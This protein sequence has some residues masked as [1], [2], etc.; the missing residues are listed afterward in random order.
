M[1]LPFRLPFR[2]RTH[3]PRH[4]FTALVAITLLGACDDPD[5]GISGSAMA[6][7]TLRRYVAGAAAVS[8]KS[9]G[10]FDLSKP[11]APG[12]RPIITSEE[13]GRLA[14]A[15][16]RSWGPSLQA[17]W[18]Q[19]RGEAIDISSL[20]VGPRTVFARTP[21]GE[22]PS[23]QHPAIVRV[24]GPYYLV[25]LY[26][27]SRPVLL[28]AVAAYNEGTK[29]NNRGLIERA[30]HRGMEFVAQALPI[31]TTEVRIV[32]PEEAVESVA[33]ATGAR[34]VTTPEL[35]RPPLP[36]SPASAMWKLTLDR[37]VSVKGAGGVRRTRQ[38][39]VGPER[40]RR[41]M[42]A[43]P[44]NGRT[45]R[46]FGVDVSGQS[47]RPVPI[48]LPIVDGESASYERVDLVREGE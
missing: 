38:I 14:L 43:M 46:G 20:T 18:S 36:Y 34:V 47:Q 1:F 42:A 45:L 44:G 2:S 25:T 37:D 19:E 3:L 21:Y 8:L 12:S 40:D 41:V 6:P 48:D 9:N 17:S 22:V 15:S 29:V 11:E 28:I 4:L 32:S 23:G 27:G 7:E 26:S 35:V 13:A 33:H 24:H 30:E 31:D 16:V 10:Q 5:D 39:F